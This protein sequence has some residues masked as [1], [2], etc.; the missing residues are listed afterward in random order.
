[1]DRLYRRPVLQRELRVLNQ[2]EDRDLQHKLDMLD[3]QHRYTCKMLQQRRDL[4]IKE[5]RRVAVVKV[6]EAKATIGIAMKEIGQR[7][8][9]ETHFRGV[10]TSDGR[11]LFSSKNQSDD[12]GCEP[13]EPSRSIS[14]PPPSVKTSSSV[15]HR[16]KVRSNLSLMQMKN[17]AAIDS[18]SEKELARQQQKAREE[19]EQQRQFQR[20]ALRE[21]VA[22]FIENLKDKSQIELLMQPP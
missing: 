10:H 15:R 12:H 19:V 3:K 17:I 13:V 22:A 21:R 2:K 11:R 20:E 7:K 14:A 5:V 8:N 18:I 4:L 16:R 9:A 6:C 1:M